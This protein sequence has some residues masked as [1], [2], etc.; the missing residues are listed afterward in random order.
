MP[1]HKLEGTI[2]SHKTDKTAVVLVERVKAHPRYQKRMK[3]S[4]KYQVDDPNNQY[5]EGEKVIIE[6]C[7][8]Q[9]KRKHWRIIQKIHD[10]S[11]DEIKNS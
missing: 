9:S 8:P 4:R 2:V 3:I 1:K 7:R 10:S 11:S 5:R 6:E